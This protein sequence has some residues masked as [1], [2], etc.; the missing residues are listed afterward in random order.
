MRYTRKFWRILGAGGLILVLISGC[1]QKGSSDQKGSSESRKAAGST[2]QEDSGLGDG[3]FARIS[4]NRGDIIVRLEYEKT[5][6]TVCNFAALAEG[7][8]NVAQGRHFYDGLIFHRVIK[9]FMIQGGDPAGN[10]SG[11]PGYQ[12]PDEF[13]PSLKHDGPGVLSMANAG[14]GTNGSQFFI[15]HVET[16][17]LDGKHTVFGRV[18]S[19]QQ[20]VNAIVQGDKIQTIT[21]IRNG[22]QANAFETDQAAFDILLRNAASASATQRQ[23]QRDADTALIKQKYPNVTAAPSGILY[24]ILASGSGVKPEAGNTVQMNYRGMFLDGTVFDSSDLHGAP[25]EFAAGRGLVIPGFDQTALD[26]RLGEKRLAIFP[27]EL[28]YGEQ[29]AGGIIP[30]NSYLVFEVELVGISR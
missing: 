16:P 28:A 1:T 8:M 9:D 30:P 12:F 29:G 27:P 22:S 14:P 11:G 25:L 19:G 10:G 18:V 2:A 13:D 24:E 17:W 7:R 3:L 6:L 5:P 20:V 23:V 15:T 21:I 4:T 26:M